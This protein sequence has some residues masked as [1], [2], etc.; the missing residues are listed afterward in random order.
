LT[1]ATP[2]WCLQYGAA[3]QQK[4]SSFSES[5]LEKVSNKDLGAVGAT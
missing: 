4:V 3:A 2:T 5:A 1:F